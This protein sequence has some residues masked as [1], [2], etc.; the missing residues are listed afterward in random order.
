ML[1]VG[2][3]TAGMQIGEFL[4]SGR[5][6][7]RDGLRSDGRGGAGSGRPPAC[8]AGGEAQASQEGR[9]QQSS[10]PDDHES[11]P[12]YEAVSSQER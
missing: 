12:E 7:G 4:E 2:Q 8:A 11:T 10:P 9:T 5:E 6:V 1:L 3:R